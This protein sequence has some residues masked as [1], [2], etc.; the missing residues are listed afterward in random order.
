MK[1]FINKYDIQLIAL[2]GALSGFL[3]LLALIAGLKE[4]QTLFSA[5]DNLSTGF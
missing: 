3:L 2:I 1:D 5:L 4:A